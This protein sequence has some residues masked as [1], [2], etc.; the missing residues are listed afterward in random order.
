MGVEFNRLAD[1]IDRLLISEREAAADLSHRLRTPLTALRLDVE[2]LSAGSE[3]ERVLDDLS[4]M[5]RTVDYVIDQA[6]RGARTGLPSTR[7]NIG[8][9]VADRVDFW[10][11]L[12]DDQ[13]REMKE[14]RASLE[15]IVAMD[16]DDA[17][18]MLDALLGNVFAHTPEGTPLGVTMVT[19]AEDV[20]LAVEDGGPGLPDEGVL[21]RGRSGG[22]SSGLG[23][24]IARRSAHAAGGDLRVGASR[25]LGGAL[26]AI[27]LPRVIS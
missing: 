27:R 10:R 21:E 16:R 25:N 20:L 6:R 24:D 5:E 3:R 15:A 23:L 2:S 1:Q 19:R 26:V 17:C 14:S 4:E 7:V 18:A 12:A 9:V 13:G 8:E 22:S 11:A